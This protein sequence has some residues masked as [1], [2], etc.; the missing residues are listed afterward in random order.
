MLLMMQNMFYA[1]S[2]LTHLN[3]GAQKKMVCGPATMGWVC[4]M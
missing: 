2:E 3:V 4:T 1:K